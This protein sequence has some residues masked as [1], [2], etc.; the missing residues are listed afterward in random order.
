[1][2]VLSGLSVRNKIYTEKETDLYSLF[3]TLV[4]ESWPSFVDS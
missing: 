4:N 3:S 2:H 1:M